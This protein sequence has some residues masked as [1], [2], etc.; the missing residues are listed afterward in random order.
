[1]SDPNFLEQALNLAENVG[2]DTSSI[3]DGVADKLPGG[4]LAAGLLKSTL[5]LNNQGDDSEDGETASDSS[6]QDA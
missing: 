6:E 1:M 3:I 4:D 5:G 2:I